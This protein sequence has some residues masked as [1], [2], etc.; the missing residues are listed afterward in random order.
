[1]YLMRVDNPNMFNFIKEELIST[2]KKVP[3]KIIKV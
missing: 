2:H 1:M 3:T